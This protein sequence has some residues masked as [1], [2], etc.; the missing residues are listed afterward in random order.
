M[1]LILNILFLIF[2]FLIFLLLILISLPYVFQLNFEYKEKFHYKI[3]VN[4]FFLKINHS[5]NH[6]GKNKNYIKL[7][8]YQHNIANK[9]KKKIENEKQ[10]K[11]GNNKEKKIIK[12]KRRFRLYIK[13]FNKRNINHLLCFLLKIY[14][15]I[16]PDDFCLNFFLSFDDPYYNGL[17]LAFYHS[18]KSNFPD[19]PL[20]ITI[21]W[22]EEVIEG[23][24]KAAGKIIPVVIIYHLLFFLFS[25]QTLKILWQLY[26]S[27]K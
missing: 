4:N 10:N 6:T 8:N 2:L 7:F 5:S 3:V 14:N 27:K 20:K 26:K 11:K 22:P 17:L 23:R 15:L 9:D 25:T 1:I 19:F 18:L 12:K 16:K 21:N 13:L 24:G